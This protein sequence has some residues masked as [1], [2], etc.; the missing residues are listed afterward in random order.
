MF[1]FDD[2]IEPSFHLAVMNRNIGMTT[3]TTK[4]RA[5][6]RRDRK[7]KVLCSLRKDNL[8]DVLKD[9]ATI[10]PKE[11]IN[12]LLSCIQSQ[13]D[14]VK[15]AAVAALGV[16]VAELAEKDMESGRVIM[17]RLMWNLNDESGGIGW[18]S[19]E[20]M[21]EIEACHR[22]LAEE[23]GSILLSY[24][25]ED[26]NY[27]EYEP[28]QRGLLWGIGRLAQAWPDIASPALP[29]LL[30]YLSSSDPIVRGHGAR[31]LGFFDDE[32]T[33]PFLEILLND[34]ARFTTFVNG[35]VLER[36]VADMAREALE[37]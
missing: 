27:L 16:S 10:P 24:C 1:R 4:K 19:P 22:G 31:A 6:S 5:L 11:I 21:G 23:F 37:R 36:S 26:G 28:L 3:R 20:A 25:R 7:E 2:T 32:S 17:R 29:L 9:L 8:A 35:K 15:W 33:K 30:P 14:R 18:G 12:S 34:E 13:E